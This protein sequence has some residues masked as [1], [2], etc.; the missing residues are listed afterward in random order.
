MV[1][2]AGEWHE[3]GELKVQKVTV[4]PGGLS[5]VAEGLQRLQDGKVSG[6]KLVYRI[7]E[8]PELA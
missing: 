5:G 7:S 4:L 2:K 6:E 1:T 3:S 8:T